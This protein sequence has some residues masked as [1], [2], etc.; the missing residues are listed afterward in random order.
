M[1][2][3][4]DC[5]RSAHVAASFIHDRFLRL[6]LQLPFK[7][8]IGDL[9]LNIQ[10][11]IQVEEVCD[12]EVGWKIQRLA[13]SGYAMPK[14][15]KGV[16][17]IGRLNWNMIGG[18]QLFGLLKR[19]QVLHRRFGV[20]MLSTRAFMGAAKVMFGQPK[21]SKYENELRRQLQRLDRRQPQKGSSH[22][23]F[24]REAFRV[25]E[26]TLGRK[27]SQT[28]HRQLIAEHGKYWNRVK[29]HK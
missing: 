28:E 18:E 24:L 21:L 17:I 25:A 20:Q 23:E 7:L 9:V 14:L 2:I 29:Q 22:A 27:L 16:K 6:P 4:T 5:K 10:E 11:L 1:A 3:M 13:R 12:S 8:G 15:A 26:E 19:C